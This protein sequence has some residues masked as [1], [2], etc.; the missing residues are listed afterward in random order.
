MKGILMFERLSIVSVAEVL[1]I[2]LMGCGKEE[3]QKAEHAGEHKA[4]HGGCLNAIGT[5]E[6]GHAEVRVEGDILKLWFVG[7]GSDTD[8]AVR[9]P[10]REF[11]LTI[12][13]RGSKETKTLVL[14]AKPV[15]IAEETVG[16]C[17]HFEGQADWL[18]GIREFTAR[19][20]VTFKGR[21]QTLQIEYPTGYDPDD[22]NKA[23]KDK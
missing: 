15:E 22:D 12:T 13:P 8:K 11:A 16:N 2:L 1:V 20:N 10:D 19:G 18:K 3:K 5:C 6:N 23:E 17:S 21:A 4:A 7:G 9:I 14:K